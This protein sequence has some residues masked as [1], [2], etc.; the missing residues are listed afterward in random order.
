MTYLWHR[1]IRIQATPHVISL[2][3]AAGAFASFTPFVGL[4]FILAGV[5]ALLV[6]GNILASALGTC[7]GNPLTFPFIWLSTFNLGG[8]ILGYDQRSEIDL[9]LPDGMWLLMFKDPSEFWSIFWA[10][11]GPVLTP[12]MLGSIPLGVTIAVIIYFIVYPA[13]EGFQHRRKALLARRKLATSSAP[14]PS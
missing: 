12:M 3:F 11:I 6:G 14:N 8:F 5:L 4:H 1:L 13:V 9:T 7:I 10:A 2:G